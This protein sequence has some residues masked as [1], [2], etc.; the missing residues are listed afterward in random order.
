MSPFREVNEIFAVVKDGEPLAEALYV[1]RRQVDE[2]NI[3]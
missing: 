1:N 2:S 3:G